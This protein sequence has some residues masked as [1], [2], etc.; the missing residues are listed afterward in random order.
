MSSE[1]KIY[2]II[3]LGGGPAGLTAAIYGGRAGYRVLVLEQMMFGGEISYSERFENYPGFPEG[4]SGPEF[5]ELMEKHALKFGA[6]LK[7]AEIKE[8]HLSGAKKKIITD[9][10]E[11]TGKKVIIAS[12]T[13]P[14]KIGI[15]GEQEYQGRGISY[16]A[17]CDG[18]FFREKAVAV[19]GGGDA[20]VEE[21]L[22][23]T[24]FVKKIYLIHRRDSLRAVRHLQEELFEN[25]KVE[26]LWNT[27]VREI[28]GA[29][30]V[31][32]LELTINGRE[33]NLPVDGV[34]IYIGRLPNT[35]F[36]GGQIETNEYGFINTDDEMRT[37]VPGV[38]A[39]GDIREKLLRQV[40]TAA[41][42]GAIA[43]YSAS[44]EL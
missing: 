6:E 22:F 13:V 38:F 36:M 28:K 39:A 27:T 4:I 40:I 20:A 23:L 35:G 14:R 30:K 33:D 21:A 10:E 11:F 31:E 7:I 41:A 37:P 29:Q 18:A 16:C 25:P 24:R 15:P 26:I 2:D 42:D 5:S 9:G 44:K 1:E 43:A 12:G 19:I 17:T 8:T 32:S 3:I 34:F